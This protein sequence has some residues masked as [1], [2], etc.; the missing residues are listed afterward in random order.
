MVKVTLECI[1]QKLLDH[2]L[3]DKKQNDQKTFLLLLTDFQILKMKFLFVSLFGVISTQTLRLEIPTRN[4][5]NKHV[6][7]LLN[8]C[9]L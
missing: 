6:S 1:T 9:K 2:F 3:W 5:Y 8:T 4:C 7:V